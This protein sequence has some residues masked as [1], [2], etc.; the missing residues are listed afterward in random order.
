MLVLVVDG[1]V[2]FGTS[3][4][5]R[6]A[7][8]PLEGEVVVDLAETTATVEPKRRLPQA[9]LL[10]NRNGAPP[11]GASRQAN[12]VALARAVVVRAV[13]PTLPPR[14]PARRTR[15]VQRPAL[16]SRVRRMPSTV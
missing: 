16:Q 5:L 15:R 11:Q 8:E 1:E 3:P 12:D 7:L 2:D 4:E 6:L 9:Q 14:R 10:T 13:L